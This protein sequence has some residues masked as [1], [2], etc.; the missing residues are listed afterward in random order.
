MIEPDQSTEPPS[1]KKKES[2]KPSSVDA[3]DQKEPG[4]QYS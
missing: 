1:S 4:K 2:E 3:E